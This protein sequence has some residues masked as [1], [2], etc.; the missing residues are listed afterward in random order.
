MRSENVK[1][2]AVMG[3]GRSG[4]TLLDNLLGSIDGVFSTGELREIW[5]G[6]TREDRLCGCGA[7][8]ASCSFWNDVLHGAN[9]DGQSIAALDPATVRTSLD[10]YVRT[11]LTPSLLTRSA[12]ARSALQPAL[13]AMNLLYLRIADVSGCSV[14]VDSSKRPA[15][16]ALLR[17]LPDVNPFV[18]HLVR[19]PRAVAFSWQ[20]EKREPGKKSGGFM[21]R[22]SL[23]LSTAVWLEINAMGS[24]VK[25]AFSS[26]RAM[27]LRYEDFVTSPHQALRSIAKL[28]GINASLPVDSDGVAHLRP[29]HTVGGNPRRFEKGAVAIRL[30]NEWRD[31]LSPAS[32]RICTA[33]TAPLVLAYGYP[34]HLKSPPPRPR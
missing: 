2:L 12:G 24:L 32:R 31:A 25:R 15:D 20:R 3:A 22:R 26:S 16:A 13:M 28:V 34:L 33:L 21:P 29:N 8:V 23:L 14:I 27:T 11:L 19:D 5:D 17:L 9:S 4:S 18:V 7:S 1:V 10:R 30:D 6:D